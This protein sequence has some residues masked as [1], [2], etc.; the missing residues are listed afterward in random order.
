MILRSS[1]LCGYTL[2][3]V[4]ECLFQVIRYINT[5]TK[6]AVWVP[7][8]CLS[9]F[10]CRLEQVAVVYISEWIEFAQQFQEWLNTP[11]RIGVG[12]D[13]NRHAVGR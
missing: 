6:L 10:S 12:V 2:L 13:M 4:T 5:N 1:P 3:Y 8:R 9:S 11:Q 7:P